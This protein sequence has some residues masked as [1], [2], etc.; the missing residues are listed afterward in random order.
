MNDRNRQE[1]AASYLEEIRDLVNRLR[2]DPKLWKPVRAG[3]QDQYAGLPPA[4]RLLD[5]I[6]ELLIKI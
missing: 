6:A 3:G 1:M 5:R 4:V 2:H